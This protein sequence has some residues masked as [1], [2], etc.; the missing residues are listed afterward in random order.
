MLNFEESTID[1]LYTGQVLFG[2]GGRLV[3]SP[4]DPP[5]GVTGL[6]RRFAL[7][8]ED[9]YQNYEQLTESVQALASA[10]KELPSAK[11]KSIASAV[12]LL[13][14]AMDFAG[15]TGHEE[16]VDPVRWC[17]E[18]YGALHSELASTFA[19]LNEQSPAEATNIFGDRE[20]T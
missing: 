8:V 6:I 5:A 12:Q 7:A 17:A 3:L 16:Y 15:R 10:L 11:A 14:T 9:M 4:G 20:P 19:R 13:A 2:Q 1:Y 18:N